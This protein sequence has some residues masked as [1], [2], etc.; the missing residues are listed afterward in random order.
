MFRVAPV[1]DLTG[2]PGFGRAPSRFPLT[3]SAL[4]PAWWARRSCTDHAGRRARPRRPGR[5]EPGTTV[6]N[7][8]ALRRYTSERSITRPSHP[9]RPGGY[10]VT[11]ASPWAGSFTLVGPVMSAGLLQPTAPVVDPHPGRV[12]GRSHRGPLGVRRRR[13][14]ERRRGRPAQHGAGEQRT[15][16]HGV[17]P[18]GVALTR[19]PRPDRRPGGP[20]LSRPCGSSAPEAAVMPWSPTRCFSVPSGG[21]PGS[22]GSGPCRPPPARP[23]ARG[24]PARCRRP[25]PAWPCRPRRARGTSRRSTTTH[26][27]T[28]T[29]A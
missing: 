23:P 15:D 27:S 14:Q 21:R 12:A 5:L 26:R 24:R 20:V 4:D 7:S 2:A 22:S 19:R 16:Q 29:P 1:L 8:C 18:D 13:L 25:G 17:E 3:R 10:P 28:P 11:T 9:A 6:M